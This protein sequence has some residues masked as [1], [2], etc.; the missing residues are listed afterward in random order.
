M[1]KGE[2]AD[3]KNSDMDVASFKISEEGCQLDCLAV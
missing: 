1:A 3:N 2:T